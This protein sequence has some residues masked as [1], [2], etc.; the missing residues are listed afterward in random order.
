MFIRFCGGSWG[1]VRG[2][3][4]LAEKRGRSRISQ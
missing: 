2:L 4:T 3:G 1:E